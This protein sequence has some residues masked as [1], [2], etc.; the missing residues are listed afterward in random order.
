MSG[1]KITIMYLTDTLI[2]PPDNPKVGGAEKQLYLLSTSLD[3]QVFKPIVVQLSP[4]QSIPLEEGKVGNLDVFHFPTRRFYDINGVRQLRKILLLAKQRKVDIIHTYFEKSE[5]LGWLI[6][7]LANIPVW[8]TSRRDLGFKRSRIY[9]RLFAFSSRDCSKCI[10]NCQAI[11]NQMVNKGSIIKDKVDVIYNGIDFSPYKKTYDDKALRQ[12]IRLKDNVRLVGMV[13]NFYHE[14]KGHQFL[15]EAAKIIQKKIPDVEFVLVGDGFLIDQYREK[16]EKM[17]LNGKVHFLGKRGDVPAILSILSVSVLCST[18]EG[19]S[20]TI[21]ESMAAGK[22]VVATRVGGNPELV[23]DGETGYLIPPA[24]SSALAQ[25]IISLLQNPGKASAMGLSGRAE[26]E[27]KFTL[28][29]MTERYE[30]L[31]KSFIS[32]SEKG[33][34]AIN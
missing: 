15:L 24:D 6:A 16:A 7:K 14:I 27:R 25:A 12:E 2:S 34:V 17:G 9:D 19:L 13:A 33:N 30:N 4:F 22:P 10:A 18:S 3:S 32:A 31:Y 29:T 23:I 26:V 28:K 11:K 20:N 5:V 8:I 1:K 21:L